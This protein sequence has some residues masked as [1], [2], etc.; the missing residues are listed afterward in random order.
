MEEKPIVLIVDDVE[1]NV[2]ILARV[3]NNDYDIKT[4]TNGQRALELIRKK[5]YP[6]L[7]LLDV[8]MPV[9]GGYEVLKELQVDSAH[10]MFPVIFIT[11]NDTEAN[12]EEG[13]R[14][15]AVDYIKKPIRPAIV[16]ARVK[17]HITLKKQR[18]KLLFD[19]V[20]DQLT[21]LYNRKHLIDEGERKFSR[22]F[23]QDDKLSLIMV[24]IDHFKAINDT[25]GHLVG[26][27]VLIQIATVLACDN[28]YEDFSARFGGEEFIVVLDGCSAD[29][30][31]MKAERFRKKIEALKPC[32]VEVTASF[33]I[34]EL[35][36]KHMN[37]DA[38][39]KDVDMALYGAK[40][41]GR[42]CSVILKD[43]EL[44]A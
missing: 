28:R 22:A 17:T 37:L 41:S 33:G 7:I 18:D 43:G 35:T 34:C 21:G 9:M 39:L 14:L 3:L 15:G 32:N 8:N 36:H 1:Q 29:S 13:L 31:K 40:E 38:L 42:N 25:Y 44:L 19:A 10:E 6:D 20:H 27:K 26:D 12:E 4:A 16:K 11:S 5:P 23:R 24:D 2:Q 30:A